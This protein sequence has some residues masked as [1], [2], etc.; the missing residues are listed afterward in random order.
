MP[1]LTTIDTTWRFHLGDP[2]GAHR[3]DFSDHVWRELDLP[4]DWSIEGE[5]D[6]QNPSGARGGF[7]PGGVAWYRRRIELPDLAPGESVRVRFDGVYWQSTVWCN[8]RVLGFRPN[9]YVSFA[10]DITPYLSDDGTALLA[11]RVDNAD[12]PN[13]RWY[14]G[15]GIYRSVHIERSGP[16]AIDRDRTTIT[17]VHPGANP[18]FRVRWEARVGRGAEKLADATAALTLLARLYDGDELVCEETHDAAHLRGRLE[19]T[20]PQPKLWS[21]ESPALYRLRLELFA[22]GERASS[23]GR[24]HPAG[25]TRSAGGRTSPRERRLDAEE[26]Q[27]GLRWVDFDPE[28]GMR[29]N[30]RPCTLRGVCEHQDAGPFGVAVP[31]DEWERRL[32]ILKTMGCN[33][34]R[35]S[36]NPP[37][38]E[39]L[40][41]ADQMGF[42]VIDEIFDEWRWAKI[43]YGYARYFDEWWER[44][45][46]D[47]VRRDRNHPS[48]IMWSVGN[49]IPEKSTAEGVRTLRHLIAAVKREDESR[50]VTAGCNRIDATNASGFA[51]LLDVVGYNGGGGSCF[52]YERDHGAYPN[53]IIYA[54]EVPHTLQTRGV[55]R[56]K[57]WFRDPDGEKLPIPDLTRTEVFPEEHEHLRS[58]YDNATVRIS[59]RDS[60]RRT[61]DLPYVLGEFRWSGFDYLGE[62]PGYP[63]RAWHFGVV[64]L[65]GFPKDTYHFYRSRWTSEPMVHLLPHWTHPG[66]EG[67][68]IPV[69]A[70]SN[71]DRV[72]LFLNDRSLGVRQMGDRMHLQWD[73][74]YEPGCLHAVGYTDSEHAATA[75]VRTA[76]APAAIALTPHRLSLPQGRNRLLHVAVTILDDTGTLVPH[77]DNVVTVRASGPVAGL[78]TENGNPLDLSRSSI[79]DRAAFRGMCAAALLTSGE[80]GTVAVRVSADGLAPARIEVAVEG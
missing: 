66:K 27:V 62:S 72:E 39:L 13:S 73:V 15:S 56:T 74:P 80:P 50:P 3:P 40:D 42:L 23:R 51:D 43:A 22:G 2:D 37:P 7:Y 19:L 16:L 1:H 26:F 59:A 34:L 77:A 69:W 38:P 60:W 41:L 35:L 71:C 29:L 76:G 47:W 52:R 17:T 61:R 12:Q 11:V 54:S 67:R 65:C 64:D 45:L 63:L 21:P 20:P 48:V 68:V 70:Y 75:T 8:G 46:T 28:R 44:D 4:H 58:S 18:G 79:R 24:A 53:R 5:I 32:R 57:T 25:A 33:A 31:R 6:E 30:G 14:S 36:H 78:V 10:Y 55:Y 9:G 49:E